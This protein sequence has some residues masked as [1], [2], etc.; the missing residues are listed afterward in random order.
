MEES[1]STIKQTENSKGRKELKIWSS[2]STTKVGQEEKKI[3][4]SVVKFCDKDEKNVK[5]EH[6]TFKRLSKPK[7]AK[8]LMEKWKAD[9]FVVQETKKARWQDREV[10][11]IRASR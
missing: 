8:F 4:N 10:R 5:L 11:Q 1:N 7:T 3:G 9:L 2:T 6:K